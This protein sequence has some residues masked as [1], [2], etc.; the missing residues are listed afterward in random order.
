MSPSLATLFCLLGIAYLFWADRKQAEGVSRAV[1]I[2]LLWMF[3][4]ASRFPSQWLDLGTPNTATADVYDEGNPLNRNVFLALIVAGVAV[5]GR[6]RVNWGEVLTANP[7][8]LFFFLFALTSTLWADDAGLSFKR[9]VKGIG[10]VVMALVILTDKRPY[11]ALGVVLRR[12]AFLLLPLSLLFIKYYPQFGRA[13]DP[14]GEQMFT[15]VAMQK[16]GLGQLCLLVGVYFA[17][18]LLF[19]RLKPNAEGRV[20]APVA[21]IVVPL[22]LWLLYTSKSA[23]SFAALFGAVCFLAVARLPFF[24]RFPRRIIGAGV[25]TVV[26]IGVLEYTL[27]IKAWAI[28]LLGRA[29]DLTERI[30]MW[31]MLLQ[32][33]P[34]T[35]IGAGYEAFWSG[36]RLREIWARMGH[37]TGFL[38]AHNGYIDAYLN[39]GI[40][41]VALIVLAIVAGLLKAHREL[42]REYAYAL[43]RIALI[44]VAIAYN[45]T[46][47]AFKPVH[48]VFVL[49][50]IAILEVPRARASRRL[51]PSGVRPPDAPPGRQPGRSVARSGPPGALPRRPASHV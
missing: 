10:D 38:Q 8:L 13:Y 14:F 35:W 5:L 12:L 39:V 33:T 44:L 46:E 4:A 19:R 31:E 11:Q 2:P 43:L 40:I 22:T 18:E 15:G 41:G 30:P 29:P 32:M 48:N 6:R 50:L 49:M 3:F 34:N 47:A 36:D 20:P 9:W 27:G 16:N 42:E 28:E 7:W 1:W 37:T 45:Y 21:L 23:T 17:W 51:A 26:A 25:S 24:A